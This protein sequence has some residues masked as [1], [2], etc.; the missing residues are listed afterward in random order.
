[1]KKFLG[2]PLVL[3][4]ALTSG[5]GSAMADS[6]TYTIDNPGSAL[7]GFAGPYATVT[8]NLIDST[9]ATITFDSSTTAGIT[10]L[11]GAS[12]VADVNVNATSWSVSGLSGTAMTGL[13][14]AL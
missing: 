8:V 2:I 4:L 1:M 9:N 6:I 11:M 13:A 10:F 7:S 3:T 12:Q 14:M 5:V